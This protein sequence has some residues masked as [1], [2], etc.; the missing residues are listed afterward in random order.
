MSNY[1]HNFFITMCVSKNC[2]NEK[3]FNEDKAALFDESMIASY[4][5]ISKVHL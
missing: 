2:F 3:V 1:A 5:F 4:N